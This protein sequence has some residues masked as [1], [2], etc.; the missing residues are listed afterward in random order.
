MSI[1]KRG[2]SWRARYRGPDHR[3][4]QRSFRRKI[5]A[6]RWLA[7]QQS[8][9]T[10]GE[11]VD[12]AAARALFGDVAREWLSAANHLKPKTRLGYE[13]LL[14]TRVL[15]TWS[16]M[17]VGKITHE[18]V[19]EWISVMA[20]AGLSASLIR[21]SVFVVSA[22]CDY[23]ART[24]RLVRN[25]VVGVKLPRIVRVRERVFLTHAQVATL[26]AAVPEH[27][28]ALI[29]ALAYT[30]MR[31]GEA[32]ALR[33][34][35]VDLARGRVD[36]SRSF[37]D[38]NGQL[39]EGTPKSHQARTIPLLPTIHADLVRLASGAERDALV[40]TTPDGYRLRSSNFRLNV[41]LPAVRAAGFDG[42]TPHGLRHTAAS[43]YIAAGTPP[44]VVQRIL[45][46][47]SVAFTLDVYGHLYPDEMDIWAAR[48]DGQMWAE[49]GRSDESE[50]SASGSV[51]PE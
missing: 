36:V 28:A 13:S 17:P 1:D 44:K 29:R 4:R 37:A 38:I 40:F 34:R 25:P 50:E 7:E 16:R 20:D 30:G 42:L 11:W 6:E 31:W 35:D 46:H 18:G 19:S 24:G 27:Y 41:W 51:T 45:G 3:Q 49:R 33:V 23:A 21:Q 43:L 22:T 14:A 2:N 47:A 15:P 10:R 48:L 5:D 9:L 8:R 32:T 12:P 26:A 39:I